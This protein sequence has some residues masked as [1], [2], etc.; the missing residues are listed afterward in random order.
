MYHKG[1]SLECNMCD[2]C[3]NQG[4]LFI[5]NKNNYLVSQFFIFSALKWFS[6]LLNTM[7]L[8]R[9]NLQPDLVQLKQLTIVVNYCTDNFLTSAFLTLKILIYRCYKRLFDTKSVRTICFTL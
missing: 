4:I 3:Q 2:V 9:K 1:D 8:M 5:T 6:K 7:V